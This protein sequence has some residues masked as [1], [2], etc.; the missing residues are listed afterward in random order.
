MNLVRHRNCER[1]NGLKEGKSKI[2]PYT[3]WQRKSK[4][5]NIT[6]AQNKE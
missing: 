3:K 5:D 2:I 6:S 1:N 4:A